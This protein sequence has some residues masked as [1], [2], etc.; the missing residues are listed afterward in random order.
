MMGD[1]Q[2]DDSGPG[3]IILIWLGCLIALLAGSPG[4]GGELV[5]A[6]TLVKRY[7]KG[8]DS[9]AT[10]A[11]IAYQCHGSNVGPMGTLRAGNGNEA[12]GVPFI[13]ATLSSGGHPNSNMP[14]RR[15]EDDVN[16]VIAT[17]LASDPIHS[18]NLAMPVTGRNGDPGTIASAAGVRRLT[19][20]ECER[21]QGF[22]DDWTLI[23]WNGKPSPDSRRYAA[24]GD[25]VTVNVAHWIAARIVAAD[26]QLTLTEVAA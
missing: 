19:P 11:L 10:D 18:V 20:R 9:D 17:T 3:T 13:A 8:T 24:L 25:A 14:G 4:S 26:H 1:F 23:P 2:D 12:G 22:P 21:L 15:K 6:P 7:A 16:L 5:T